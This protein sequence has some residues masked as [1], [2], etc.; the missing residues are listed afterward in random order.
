L[1]ELD[2][3]VVVDAGLAGERLAGLVSALAAAG[4]SLVVTRSC[5]L[6]LR[7][8]VAAHAAADGVVLVQEGGRALDRRDVAQVLGLPVLASVECDPAVARSVD[9]G[10]LVRRPNRGLER[11]LRDL[12]RVGVG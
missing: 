11:S 2:R 5:Y 12:A 7:R 1:T 3:P 8:A 10:L 6:A 9:A 4:T